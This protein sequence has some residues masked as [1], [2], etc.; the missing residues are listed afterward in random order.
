[1][2]PFWTKLHRTVVFTDLLIFGLIVAWFIVIFCHV[3]GLIPADL[4]NIMWTIHTLF[5]G[6][7]ALWYFSFKARWVYT[8]DE[9]RDVVTF[10]T[11]NYNGGSASRFNNPNGVWK[12]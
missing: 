12:L 11:N 2:E 3:I 9:L 1:M 4:V 7:S 10:N 6:F 5:G 8:P